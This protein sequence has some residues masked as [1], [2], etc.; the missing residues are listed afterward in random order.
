MIRTRKMAKRRWIHLALL[1]G[2]LVIAGCTRARPEAS[3]LLS[4]VD[5]P[6]GGVCVD[7]ETGTQMTLEEAISIAQA[8]ACTEEGALLPEEAQCNSLTGTWWIDL[9]IDQP[10]CAPAC[11]VSLN[12]RTAEINWRCTGVVV[13]E[14]ETATVEATTAATATTEPA[15]EGAPTATPE[16]AAEPTAEPDAPMAPADLTT[17]AKFADADYGFSFRY[18]PEWSIELLGDRP[19]GPE[20]EPAAPAIRLTQDTLEILIEY[21]HPDEDGIIGPGSLPE[22]IVEDR[23]NVTL[24]DREVPRHVLVYEGKDKSVFVGD[25]FP[26]I[27]LYIQMNDNRGDDYAAAAIPQEAHEVFE[28]ILATFTRTTSPTSGDP[29]QDWGSFTSEEIAPGYSFSFRY[30]PDW[31]LTERPAGTETGTGP[32]AAMAELAKEAYV[33]QIQY[34]PVDDESVMITGDTPESLVMEAGTAW[35]MSQPVSRFVV[36]SDDTLQR[37]LL[38]Y[39]DDVMLVS[40]ELSKDPTAAESVEGDIPPE[41]RDEVDQILASFETTTP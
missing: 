19:A 16:T 27:E 29:Y 25:R 39:S 1:A 17:W 5:V 33:L 32:A 31:S 38:T 41:I 36:V 30:P 8:S 11:V 9:D 15:T 4:D 14:D 23:G 34:K 35:F 7:D 26:D 10:G 40:V 18:P 13:P 12:D 28:A 2:A 37:V 21:K 3:P 6:V 22:G 20:G 24:F